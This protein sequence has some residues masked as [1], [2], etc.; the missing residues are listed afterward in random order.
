[1]KGDIRSP[2][3]LGGSNPRS[4]STYS[5]SPTPYNSLLPPRAGLDFTR[6]LPFVIRFFLGLSEC[7]PAFQGQQHI[8]IL[9]GALFLGIFQFVH[10][11]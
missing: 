9:S 10:V 11:N 4:A 2:G 5:R 6:L 8:R 1:M 3:H 7:V